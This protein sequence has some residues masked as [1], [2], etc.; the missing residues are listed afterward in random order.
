MTSDEGF[1]QKPTI[2]KQ[3]ATEGLTEE[4]FFPMESPQ[5]AASP[6]A[7]TNSPPGEL[8]QNFFPM[9][10]PAPAESAE[11]EPLEPMATSASEAEAAH[12]PV[13]EIPVE[14]LELLPAPERGE[15]PATADAAPR[16]EEIIPMRFQRAARAPLWEPPANTSSAP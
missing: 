7:E 11:I 5:P 3:S 15:K 9:Q 12:S 4:D 14:E 2:Q 10:E 8:P 6:A 16:L 1:N 13:T